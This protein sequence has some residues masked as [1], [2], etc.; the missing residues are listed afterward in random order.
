MAGIGFPRFR[1]RAPG[2]ALFGL[3]LVACA[4]GTP[5]TGAQ[6]EVTSSA[7]APV[8]NHLFFDWMEGERVLVANRRV[9]AQG[10]L[11]PA[12]SPLAVVRIASDAADAQRQ[13][14]VRGMIDDLRVSQGTASVRIVKG[15]WQKA[16]VVLAPATEPPPDAGA[17]PDGAEP[18]GSAEPDAAV[19]DAAL[20]DA[21]SP[22]V[23]ADGP[24]APPDVAE[25]PDAQAPDLREVAADMAPL[26]PVTIAPTADTYVEQGQSAGGMNYGKAAVLEVKTQG[27]A[28]NNR[29]AYLRFPL[30]AA[31]GVAVTAT[32]RLYG[33]S[34]AGTMVES[35]Y[36]VTDDSWSETG[37]TWNNKPP[38]GAKQATVN[39]TTTAQY[40]AW[41]VSNIVKAQVAAGRLNVNLAVQMDGDTASSPD[42]HNSREAASNPPQLVI[43]R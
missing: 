32:L 12:A 23:P 2:A 35:A 22:E 14:L 9:P 20:P 1:G 19:P 40:R 7:G 21:D 31:G 33:R 16:T 4:E 26:G 43:N 27:G 29:I 10:F 17:P 28:D 15:T 30:G 11:D 3:L 39:V 42:T 24:P 6:I 18:D 5:D 41:D 13:I 38:L 8:P 25:P 34:A 36:A 37:L